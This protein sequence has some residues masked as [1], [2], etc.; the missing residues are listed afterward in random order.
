MDIKYM[1]LAIEEAKKAY[2]HNEV[3]VG[4]VI[5]C[6][7]KVIAKAYNKREGSQNSLYHAEILCINKAC[8]KLKSWRLDECDIYVTLEPCPMCSGAII[9]SKI[10][11]I[12]Y[13]AKDYK[14]GFAGGKFNVFDI[15]FNYSPNVIGG[16]MEDECQIL[17]KDF[18]K[19]LREK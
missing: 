17:I 5:V 12:Y 10:K 11:N 2:K 7:N 14:T 9:Q 1:K 16:I 15:K 13:G 3:P 19:M 4:C 8:K 6:D 18:F